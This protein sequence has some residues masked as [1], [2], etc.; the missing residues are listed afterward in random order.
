M[1]INRVLNPI[2]NLKQILY[3]IRILQLIRKLNFW[4]DVRGYTSLLTEAK[5]K[6]TVHRSVCV[7]QVLEIL[8][9]K[10]ESIRVKKYFLIWF[11]TPRQTKISKNKMYKIKMI[12]NI[13]IHFCRF[14]LL[15]SRS[16]K[17]KSLL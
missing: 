15:S 7:S 11:L 4:V 6:G 5:Q 10:R 8:L 9:H 2:K 17:L 3:S 12:L 1:I 14:R 16:D 13:Y